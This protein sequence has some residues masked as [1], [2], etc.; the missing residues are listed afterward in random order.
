[1]ENTYPE[2]PD[3]WIL[4]EA[5]GAVVGKTRGGATRCDHPTN[6]T[7]DSLTA[8]GILWFVMQKEYNRQIKCHGGDPVAERR[9]SLLDLALAAQRPKEAPVFLG[10]SVITLR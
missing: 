2:C 6:G 7:L 5:A 9:P 3:E 10:E 4:R 8:W 1:D